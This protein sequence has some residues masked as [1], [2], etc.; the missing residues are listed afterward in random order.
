MLSLGLDRPLALFPSPPSQCFCSNVLYFLV[1]CCILHMW[2]KIN[3]VMLCYVMLCYVMLCYVMLCYVMLCYDMLT[4]ATRCGSHI[5]VCVI[6]VWGTVQKN[7]SHLGH[8]VI[9]KFFCY[10][11]SHVRYKY[12]VPMISSVIALPLGSQEGRVPPWQW[13]NLPKIGE[14]RGKRG[15]KS[16]K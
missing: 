8:A 5:Q 10:D 1:F 12:R 16:G 2:K 6:C 7:V 14:K 3:Y 13:K 15:K 9:R 4:K 11:T